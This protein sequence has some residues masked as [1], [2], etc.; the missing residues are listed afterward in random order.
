[1]KGPLQ[2]RLVVAIG[3]VLG[4]S[5]RLAFLSTTGEGEAERWLV[6]GLVNVVGC[7]VV[8]ATIAAADRW[9]WSASW[10]LAATV[11][12]CGGLTTFSTV[13]V[14]VALALADGARPAAT[15]IGWAV[16]SLGLGI[17]AVV[18]GRATVARRATEARRDATPG[19]AT[20]CS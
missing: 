12:V 19:G 17:V 16:L 1:M 7:F 13:A 15:A 6:L 11:G 3:G 9:S 5:L 18:A 10:R 8:G 14:E 20:R 4:A 2:L